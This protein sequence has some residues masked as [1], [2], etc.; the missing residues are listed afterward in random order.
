MDHNTFL[1]YR[2]YIGIK[3][4]FNSKEFIYHPDRLPLSVDTF[5][6]RRDVKLFY[7]FSKAYPKRDERVELLTTGFLN[8]KSSY[9]L[10]FLE[11]EIRELHID[12][13]KRRRAIEYNFDMAV[14]TILD[15]L[16]D[17]R[18]FLSL[19]KNNGNMPEILS[20]KLISLENLA[21]LDSYFGYTRFHSSNILWEEKRQKISKY[22]YLLRLEEFN[23][24]P[25]IEKLLAHNRVNPTFST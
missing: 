14:K 18:T 7:R 23:L 19:L 9:I 24:K 8:D 10:S 21:I 11:D 13:M 3:L 6:K 1:S 22:K 12:R 25:Q 20:K 5:R 4:H 2:D 15:Y 16:E 17:D